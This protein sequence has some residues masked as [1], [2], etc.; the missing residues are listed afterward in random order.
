[1]GEPGWSVSALGIRHLDAFETGF[2]DIVTLLAP[3]D[4]NDNF[5]LPCEKSGVIRQFGSGIMIKTEAY[6]SLFERP[7]TFIRSFW[8]ANGRDLCH[9]MGRQMLKFGY[10]LF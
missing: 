3:C 1:M 6:H 10:S 5:V 7:H 8:A 9:R 4:M 2:N